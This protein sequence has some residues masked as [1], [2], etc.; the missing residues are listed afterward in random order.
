MKRGILIT[1]TLVAA[2]TIVA[3]KSNGAGSGSSASKPA[4]P[5][6][7]VATAANA[8]VVLAW[9][10]V[11]GATKYDV[12]Y[13]PGTAATI[14]DA[15]FTLITV[16]DATVTVPTL[17]NGTAYVFLVA[18][19]NAEGE[20]AASASATATPSATTT[21]TSLGS[22][23]TIPTTIGPGSFTIGTSVAVSSALTIAP[24][25]TLSF[26]KGIG[27]TVTTAGTITA[28]GTALLPIVFTSSA[29]NPVKGDAA[30]ITVYGT[31]AD[32]EYCS[33]SYMATALAVSGANAKIDHCTFTANTTG[34][35]G[36]RAAAGTTFANN[37]F[38]TNTV[39]AWIDDQFDVDVDNV[40]TTG[41]VAANN[42]AK[43]TNQ[44]IYVYGNIATVRVWGVTDAAYYLSGVNDYS[45]SAALT[46]KPG[47]TLK[48]DPSLSLKISATGQLN[49][50]GSSTAPIVFTSIKDDGSGG[51]S[52]GNGTATSP[53]MSDWGGVYVEGA[54]SAVDYCEFRYGSTALAVPANS[55][56][57][58]NSTFTFNAIGL[59]E[60]N[61]GTGRTVTA[62]TFYSNNLPLVT[63]TKNS[64]DSDNVFHNPALAATKNKFQAIQV[65]GDLSTAITWGVTEAAY[66]FGG[67]NDYHVTAAVTLKPSVVFKFD[68]GLALYLDANGSLSGFSGAVFSSYKDDSVGGDSNGD[69]TASTAGAT[70]WVG[71]YNNNV[72]AYEAGANIT[73]AVNH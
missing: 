8:S 55:V 13:K 49:A 48:F 2:L 37:T 54:S 50:K 16:T 25:T 47:V 69:G 41:T 60:G 20:G 67:V 22:T 70:D 14:S 15:G 26:D 4:A 63:G 46:L 62:N 1:L 53:A 23:V 5:T 43:N 39:P 33:F 3:C 59:D 28:K 21:V 72:G 35:D 29:G 24:G 64:L 38:A 36:S 42:V 68:S 66:Y 19:V 10:A 7:L 9:T 30:G 61:N 18:A 65:Y 45:V 71:I 34:F 6:G 31:N 40:F 11:S 51:D 57:V 44:A 56:P 27:I 17:T 32:F 73:Y 52:N 58:S 12:Y